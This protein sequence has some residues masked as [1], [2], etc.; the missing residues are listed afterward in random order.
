MNENAL[1]AVFPASSGTLQV[2]IINQVLT[3]TIM[4]V[5]GVPIWDAE[6]IEVFSLMLYK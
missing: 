2:N 6:E 3:K 5:Q 4:P 1:T